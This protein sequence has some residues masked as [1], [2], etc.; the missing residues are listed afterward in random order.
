MTDV[1][2]RYL[3]HKEWFIMS[4]WTT[5]ENIQSLKKKVEK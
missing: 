1:I 4:I 5:I 3:K 2:I